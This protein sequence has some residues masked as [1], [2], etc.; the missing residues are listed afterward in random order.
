MSVSR[1]FREELTRDFGFITGGTKEDL[2]NKRPRSASRSASPI[3]NRSGKSQIQKLKMNLDLETRQ[4][5]V[6][7]Y[8]R[9]AFEKRR[10]LTKEITEPEE[11]RNN[12]PEFNR[13]K[14]LQITQTIEIPKRNCIRNSFPMRLLE[15]FPFLDS[16]NHYEDDSFPLFK[17]FD[18]A[19]N[20]NEIQNALTSIISIDK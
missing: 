2:P 7:E 4:K 9:K 15:E 11:K 5:T 6:E 17:L 12:T 8:R 14:E 1:Q 19:C 18:S 3:S 20:R 13:K 16:P 10:I